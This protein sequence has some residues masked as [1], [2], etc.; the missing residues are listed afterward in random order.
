[1]GDLGD[2]DRPEIYWDNSS[3]PVAA[4]IG[5]SGSHNAIIG[6]LLLTPGTTDTSLAVACPSTEP[7]FKIRTFTYGT[8]AEYSVGFVIFTLASKVKVD[9]VVS[10]ISK[11]PTPRW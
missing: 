4:P 1:M 9:L 5:P 8:V 6:I 10:E 3:R 7:L 11:D 2:E